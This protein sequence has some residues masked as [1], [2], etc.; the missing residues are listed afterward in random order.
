MPHVKAD[1][2]G[3]LSGWVRNLF[4][5]GYHGHAIDVGAS[6]GISISSSWVL[7]KHHGWTVI[8]VEANP[9]FYPMLDSERTWVEKCAVA[10]ESKDDQEF[11]VHEANPESFSALRPIRNGTMTGAG[12]W[13]QIDLRRL[14]F[15]TIRVPVRTLDEIV[16]KWQL[17]KV[18]A[19]FVDVEGGELDVLRGFD[20]ARWRP[21]AIIT[22][23]WTP[24]G[25]IDTY[26]A[27]F[28]YK[29]TARNVHNDL[30][31]RVD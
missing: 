16:D 28:R 23:C 7:E 17:P 25:P 29:K 19:L 27:A 22:E 21:K 4:P 13:D 10:D 8:C 20:I 18:D 12:Q 26:L 11:S 31:I 30:F 2:N 3:H 14:K 15:S 1:P 9:F 5:S 24:T 6:D